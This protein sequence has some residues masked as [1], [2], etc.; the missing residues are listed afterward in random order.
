[1]HKLGMTGLSITSSLLGF[2]ASLLPVNSYAKEIVDP[3]AGFDKL[4]HEVMIDITIIGVIFGLI[5]IY[6]MFKY[7]RR[8]END[9]GSQ[10]QMSHLSSVGWAVIPV[11]MFL[12]DDLYMAANGWQLYN[13]Y[14][15]VPED[16]FEVKLEAAM[17]TWDYTYPNGAKTYNDLRVPAGRPIVLRMTS[18]DTLHSHYIPDFRIKED[19]MPGR[20]TYI[21]FYPKEP[22]EHV[23]T[24]AEYCGMLHSK[25]YGKVTVMAE[26]DFN[27][28]YMAEGNKSEQNL[29]SN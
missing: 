26:D 27:A 28:W 2:I 3:A 6:F 8:N 21:W 9:E 13:D 23:V 11:F 17:W 1:M 18:R 7:R 19:S 15:N 16:A 5:M 20:V 14:R 4:W 22:G 10:Q 25:M 12:A 24:C 29:A